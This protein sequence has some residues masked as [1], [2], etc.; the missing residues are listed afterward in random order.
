M[1]TLKVNTLEEATVGGATFY[2]AKTWCNADGVGTVSIRGSGNCSSIVDAA[3]GKYLISFTN[4]LSNTTYAPSA[5]MATVTNTSL[6][7]KF[8]NSGYNP[9][10]LTSSC[11]F[12]ASSGANYYDVDY[13]SLVV[14]S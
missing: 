11:R 1:S 10:L 5:S 6:S 14:H 9:A 3:T 12:T 7:T 8:G 13:V 4:N 2:T